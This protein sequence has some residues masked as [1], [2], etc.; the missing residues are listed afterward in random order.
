MPTSRDSENRSTVSWAMATPSAAQVDGLDDGLALAH[1]L[2]A[3]GAARRG[4]PACRARAASSGSRPTTS[5][6]LTSGTR[7]PRSS[8]SSTGGSPIPTTSASAVPCAVAAPQGE[9]AAADRD[10][11]LALLR[12]RHHLAVGALA[13]DQLVDEPAR[14]VA[15][16]GH[17]LGADAVGVDRS[18][19]ERRDG[20]LVE[21]AGDHDP[22]VAGA[23]RVELVADL[24]GEHAQV[25]GVEPDGAEARSRRPRRR[26]GPPRR[27]RRCRPAAWCRRRASRPAR[28]TRR[29][30]S[31]GAG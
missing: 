1:H 8:P 24:V 17:Q 12:D 13:G 20:V 23:E 31:R 10:L 18:G 6:S 19:G 27:C 22:G 25:A 15:A 9:L 26:A 4:T 2:G 21:V 5:P 3:D 30:R 28:G 29:T 16:A 14:R 7:R 11:V